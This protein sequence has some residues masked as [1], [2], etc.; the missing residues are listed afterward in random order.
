MCSRSLARVYGVAKW[1]KKVDPCNYWGILREGVSVEADFKV[2]AS[3][4]QGYSL[5]ISGAIKF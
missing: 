5:Q 2:E 3:T 4:F 1:P